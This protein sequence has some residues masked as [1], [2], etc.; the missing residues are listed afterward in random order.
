MPAI[1]LEIRDERIARTEVQAMRMCNWTGRTRVER[2]RSVD[3]A[4]T[5]FISNLWRSR[6]SG[7]R[8]EAATF[9]AYSFF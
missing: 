5:F 8:T 9:A 3:L 1:S 6:F 4:N 7:L 2:R